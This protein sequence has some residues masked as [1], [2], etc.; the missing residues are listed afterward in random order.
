MSITMITEDAPLGPTLNRVLAPFE[1][2]CL[3]GGLVT[4]MAE[5]LN[6]ELVSLLE[7]RV[8]QLHREGLDIRVAVTET[9]VASAV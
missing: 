9:A 1:G 7:G 3:D 6:R 4:E 5:T 8:I 2:R